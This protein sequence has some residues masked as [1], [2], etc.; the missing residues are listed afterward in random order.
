MNVLADNCMHSTFVDG[1]FRLMF[2]DDCISWGW[3]ILG[4]VS[5]RIWEVGVDSILI[6]VCTVQGIVTPISSD[7]R[8]WEKISSC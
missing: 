3:C 7:W 1:S 6:F 2:S 5:K 4:V 8:R